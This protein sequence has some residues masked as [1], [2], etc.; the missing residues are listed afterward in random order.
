[1]HTDPADMFRVR[2][3]AGDRLRATLSAPGGGLTLSLQIPAR[4]VASTKSTQLTFRAR[5]AG[6]YYVAVTV[7]R[8]PP[9]G[10]D[11]TLTLRR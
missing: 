11:Y 5:R 6:V 2:L 8:T 1:M 9:A 7:Q 4:L 10:T 3:K